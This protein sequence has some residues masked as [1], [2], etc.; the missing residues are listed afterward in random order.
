MQEGRRYPLPEHS[1]CEQGLCSETSVT[2]RAAGGA[3][4]AEG[5][6]AA[7]ADNR[8]ARVARGMHHLVRQIR[9]TCHYIGL[10]LCLVYAVLRNARVHGLAPCTL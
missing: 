9:R 10:L 3:A 7:A 8:T 4:A 5:S 2:R 6:H 1:P